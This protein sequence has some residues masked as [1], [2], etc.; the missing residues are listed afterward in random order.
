MNVEFVKPRHPSKRKGLTPV[1][2]SAKTP[3]TAAKRKGL[4]P[5]QPSAKTPRT[6]AN[7]DEYTANINEDHLYESLFKV[8]PTACLFTIIPEPETSPSIMPPLCTMDRQISDRQDDST[9]QITGDSITL[10]IDKT[11]VQTIED[12]ATLDTTERITDDSTTQITNE[13]L[14]Q[15]TRD[16]AV[17]IMEDTTADNTTTQITNDTVIQLAEDTTTSTDNA[18]VQIVHD[19]S[20]YITDVQDCSTII[21]E[22]SIATDSLN[23]NLI[24]DYFDLKYQELDDASLLAKAKEIFLTMKVSDRE[25]GAIEQSTK[26]QRECDNWFTYRK[27]R[28][29]ASLFHDIY[30]LKAKTDP[31]KLISKLLS[32]PNLSQI[33]AVKWGIDHEDLARQE[34]SS[35]MSEFIVI[36]NVIHLD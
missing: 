7:K 1:Q 28:I 15:T 10:C 6:A 4:T 23:S 2:P 24:V 33:P 5:V 14:T 3:R 25:C 18:T 29:T 12:T 26:Q 32:S 27:G 34:Y 30:V 16:I 31:K 19:T 21:S 35:A 20:S 13:A 11:T 22:S 9:A 17:Q 36:L 8:N